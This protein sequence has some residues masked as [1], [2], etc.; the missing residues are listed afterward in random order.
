MTTPTTYRIQD[1]CH[2]CTK[3]F[4]RDSVGEDIRFYCAADKAPMPYDFGEPSTERYYEQLKWEE[5]RGVEPQ[6]IC[7]EYANGTPRDFF[8]PEAP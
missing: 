7:D 3:C 2:N 6:G 8:Q 1:G 4:A 5:G